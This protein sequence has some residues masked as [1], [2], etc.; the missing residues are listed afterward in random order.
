[1]KQAVEEGCADIVEC[2]LEAGHAVV[3]PDESISFI[4]RV[5][6]RAGHAIAMSKVAEVKA[7]RASFMA[8]DHSDQTRHM[9][10]KRASM[11]ERY[12]RAIVIADLSLCHASASRLWPG[13]GATLTSPMEIFNRFVAPFVSAQPAEDASRALLLKH[14]HAQQVLITVALPILDR[15]TGRKEGLAL[16]AGADTEAN[17]RQK[18]VYYAAAL[19]IVQALEPDEMIDKVYASAG[20]SANG[21]QRLEH[22]AQEQ[23]SALQELATEAG[24]LLFGEI[25][26]EIVPACLEHTDGRYETDIG[27][28]SKRFVAS[29]LIR[30]LANVVAES[31]RITIDAL[32]IASPSNPSSATPIP[33]ARILNET[34]STVAEPLLAKTLQAELRKPKVV[35]ELREMSVAAG[36]DF[37]L[38]PLFQLQVELL[39]DYCTRVLES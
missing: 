31:W 15:L 33:D 30:P 29:G 1:M 24:A 35:S 36:T 7:L 20:I 4:Y 17:V 27:A 22:A 26:G 39:K 28:L 12:A 18:A 14:L 25:L 3:I 13:V 8:D 21:V 23:R 6:G 32:K 10:K 38:D 2:L 9:F 34:I 11:L 16:L 37:A 5:W 19:S